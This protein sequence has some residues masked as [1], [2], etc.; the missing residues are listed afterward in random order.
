M[1]IQEESQTVFRVY[2]TLQNKGY[3]WLRKCIAQ[4]SALSVLQQV[5]QCVSSLAQSR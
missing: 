1:R 3:L 5:G 2:F 4:I